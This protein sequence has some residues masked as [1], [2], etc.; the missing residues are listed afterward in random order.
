M[1]GIWHCNTIR[2]LPAPEY[3]EQGQG[4]DRD[5]DRDRNIDRNTDT[6]TLCW[7]AKTELKLV[8]LSGSL[9]ALHYGI[10]IILQTY[11]PLNT[12][13]RVRARTGTGT[14]T[15]TRTRT[16]TRFVGLRKLNSNW[17]GIEVL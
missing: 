9:G 1:L 4:T 8:W 6:E 2:E 11:R 3:R 16:R 13:S 10:L 17:C 14:G 15:R 12:V 7:I 5:R